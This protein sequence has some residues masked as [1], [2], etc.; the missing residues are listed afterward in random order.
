MRYH[1][2]DTGSR[3][4]DVVLAYPD[5]ALAYSVVDL[6]YPLLTRLGLRLSRWNNFRVG[7]L[8]RFELGRAKYK[9]QEDYC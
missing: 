8:R 4:D 3:R 7:D 6:A 1:C 5:V 2:A 9:D